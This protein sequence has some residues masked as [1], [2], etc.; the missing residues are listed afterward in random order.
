VVTLIG[1]FAAVLTTVCW[2]PQVI[3]TMRTREA[4]DFHWLW[5]GMLGIGVAAWFTYGILQHAAPI[6]VANG[7]TLCLLGVI[8]IVKARPRAEL[9]EAR[10][11]EQTEA[12]VATAKTT[13]PTAVPQ[14]A[15]SL[16]GPN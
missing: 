14:E 12:K 9:S 10:L 13:V 4:G 5:L 3:M 11:A 15:K 6:Y 16:T 7:V 1:S 2:L 8:A